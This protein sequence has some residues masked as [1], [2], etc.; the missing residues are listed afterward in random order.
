ME[1]QVEKKDGRLEAFDRSKIINGIL[2][3]G[4]AQEEAENIANQVENWAKS[5]AVNGVI[6]TMDIGT[7][8]LELL[9][10]I[11]PAAAAAFQ[12]YKKPV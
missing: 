12:T 1:L 4:A 2:K 3:S 9:N 8:V 10:M 11:D 5:T 6:K 7:K